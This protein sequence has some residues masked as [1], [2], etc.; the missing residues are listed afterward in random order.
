MAVSVN[1]NGK[2]NRGH[3]FKLESQPNLLYNYIFKEIMYYRDIETD[4]KAMQEHN[5]TQKAI[6]AKRLNPTKNKPFKQGT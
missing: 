3:K 4:P 2:I 6:A 5:A 1:W